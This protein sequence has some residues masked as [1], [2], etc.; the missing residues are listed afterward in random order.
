MIKEFFEIT[1]SGE[2][3]K[4]Y[5]YLELL[6]K[7]KLSSLFVKRDIVGLEWDSDGKQ[8]LLNFDV[9]I[10]SVKVT[11]DRKRIICS[12]SCELLIYDENAVLN[13]KVVSPLV[14]GGISYFINDYKSPLISNGD[15]LSFKF[16]DKD[17]DYYAEINVKNNEVLNIEL[18][19]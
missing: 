5:W 6:T 3:L 10:S 17:C 18:C 19:R 9:P 4:E 1:K 11:E 2:R 8:F 7:D 12:K 14:Y 15:V 13:Y 16:S